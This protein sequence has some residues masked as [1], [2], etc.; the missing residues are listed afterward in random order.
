MEPAIEPLICALLR[1]DAARWPDDTGAAFAARFIDCADAHR[2]LPLLDAELERRN[3]RDR[4][5]A[6]IR[7][8][9]RERRRVQALFE[10]A[11]GAE[12]AQVI[13]ALAS[14]GIPSILLKGTAL[15]Y[16]R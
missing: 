10:L 2:V 4:W 5:P 1:R 13:D 15:A 6:A 8:A 9:C 7:V 12:I 11:H 14:R 16:G 3:D